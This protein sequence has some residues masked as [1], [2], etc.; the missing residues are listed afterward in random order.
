MKKK[1]FFCIL[2]FSII[3]GLFAIP[4]LTTKTDIN[5][6]NYKP[7]YYL[8]DS[9]DAYYEIVKENYSYIDKYNKTIRICALY[10]SKH[11]IATDSVI[12]L[13][14]AFTSKEKLDKFADSIDLLDIENEFIKLRKQLINDNAEILSS[15]GEDY[16]II[17]YCREY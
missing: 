11:F 7:Y 14:I 8:S 9:G 6:R 2:F 17:E 5:D 10:F 3:V 12:G 13:N 15:Y 4:K 16:F 1:L